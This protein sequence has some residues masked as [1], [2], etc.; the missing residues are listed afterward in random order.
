MRE[1]ETWTQGLYARKTGRIAPP[2][3][4]DKTGATDE[5]VVTPMIMFHLL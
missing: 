3:R 5:E 1:E 4:G 2:E